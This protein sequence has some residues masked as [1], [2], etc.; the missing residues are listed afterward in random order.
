[1]AVSKPQSMPEYRWIH[2][3]RKSHFLTDRHYPHKIDTNIATWM[4]S[5]A[6]SHYSRSNCPYVV[7]KFPNHESSTYARAGIPS[8][9]RYATLA[10]LKVW[11]THGLS[12]TTR[13][14]TRHT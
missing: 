7:L 9:R 4:A 3:G 8:H 14:K 13:G 6:A 1:M 5:A 10:S 11:Y 12:Q 2:V